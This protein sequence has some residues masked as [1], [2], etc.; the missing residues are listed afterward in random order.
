MIRGI[1]DRVRAR[2]QHGRHVSNTGPPSSGHA[3]GRRSQQQR[4]RLG[5]RETYL[6]DPLNADLTGVGIR[7]D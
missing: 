7:I 6:A 1:A 2:E 3:R 4:H 5:Y